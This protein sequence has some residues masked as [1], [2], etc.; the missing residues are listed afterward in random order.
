MPHLRLPAANKGL[1]VSDNG[2]PSRLTKAEKM[3]L[4]WL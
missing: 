3:V 2:I 4:K 1:E